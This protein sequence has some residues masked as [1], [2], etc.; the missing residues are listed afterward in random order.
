[1]ALEE[2][3]LSSYD[4]NAFH[5]DNRSDSNQPKPVEQFNDDEADAAFMRQ[6]L[7]HIDPNAVDPFDPSKFDEERME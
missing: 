5:F 4:P 1:M 3:C 2:H 7:P 6:F